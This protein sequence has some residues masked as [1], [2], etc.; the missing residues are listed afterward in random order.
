M[1]E[2]FSPGVY[3]EEY[4]NSPRSIE[5]VGTST[6]GFVGFAE[7]GP[8]EGAPLLVP[9]FKAFTQQFGGFLSEFAYGEYRFLAHSVEQFFANGGTRCFVMRVAPKDAAVAKATQGILKVEAKNPGT[10]GNKIQVTL[11]TVK[12]HKMQ[13]IEATEKA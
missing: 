4:D 5:G 12:K 9:S 2:Y 8:V 3:V 11:N 13:L 7:K 10:W 6:A 1:A